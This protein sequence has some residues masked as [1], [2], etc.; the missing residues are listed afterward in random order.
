MNSIPDF[1]SS[2]RCSRNRLVLAVNLDSAYIEPMT[3]CLLLEQYT[4]L[5]VQ[6]EEEAVALLNRLYRQDCAPLSILI[7]LCENMS[8]GLL[9]AAWVR[10][11]KNNWTL[12]VFPLILAIS[13]S[14]R[15]VSEEF[16]GVH[17]ILDGYSG[18]I[19]RTVKNELKH[20]LQTSFDASS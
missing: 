14:P 17:Q 12:Q 2:L 1:A 9:L 16:F 6:G 15:L 11:H 13:W 5:A 3:D 18:C 8:D 7:H 20:W 19:V 4:P 10:A